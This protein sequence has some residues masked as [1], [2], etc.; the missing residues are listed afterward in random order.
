MKSNEEEYTDEQCH[1]DCLIIAKIMVKAFSGIIN[2]Y[3][4][5][6][7]TEKQRET[8][9]REALKRT[10]I[11]SPDYYNLQYKELEDATGLTTEAILLVQ[12]HQNELGYALLP[13]ND[14]IEKYAKV[15][16]ALFPT[17]LAHFHSN[18]FESGEDSK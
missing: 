1:D 18:M 13:D 9:G 17:V 12:L 11:I 15:I 14:D 6:E 3:R 7:K 10:G 2:V 4:I 5:E 8:D 16:K